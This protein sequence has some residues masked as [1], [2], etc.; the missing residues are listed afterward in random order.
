MSGEGHLIPARWPAARKTLFER[1]TEAQRVE[2]E[3][4]PECGGCG[5]TVG[6]GCC[7]NF[8]RDGSCRG[9][10]AVQTQYQCGYCIGTCVDPLAG[11]GD[12][13]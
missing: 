4:C 12:H 13:A 1:M 10:C 6:P 7:G 3:P 2:P 8:A 9:H 11:E 5:Y